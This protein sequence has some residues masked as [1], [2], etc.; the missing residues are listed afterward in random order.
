[1]D[2]LKTVGKR[3]FLSEVIYV[4]LNLLLAAAL[5]VA[6]LVVNVPWPAL[7]LVLLSKWRIFAV[8]S[9]YWGANIRANLIDIIVGVGMVIFLY[10]ANGDLVVQIIL[11]VLY[12]GWLLLIKPRSKRA[13]VA[14]QA[15]IGLVVGIGS[16][17]QISPLL[18]SSVVV[19]AAWLV[20]YSAA[21]HILSVQ[22]ESHINFLSLLW[23][24]VVAEVMWLTYHWTIGYA[25]FGSLQLSQA[26]V[27]IAALSFVAE[28]TY[29]SFHRNGHVQS[30]DVV[31]P[32][33]LSLSVIGVLL[34]VFGRAATI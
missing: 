29:T 18:P 9:R 26:M 8:R 32:A 25:V 7:G 28:R 22:H 11:T 10:S 33:L 5:L 12:A 21:R 23:G 4:V 13:Y 15:L 2:L 17:V 24:F 16:I 20:G 1:M 34:V 19:I 27:I 14:A 31:L 6:V 30:N 3:S